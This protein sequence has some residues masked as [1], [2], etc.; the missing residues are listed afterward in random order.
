MILHSL[1][2]ELN[3]FCQI[4]DVIINIKKPK[5]YLTFTKIIFLNLEK[6]F[7]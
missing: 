5:V 2:F 1:L 3:H 4:F 6:T 7:F